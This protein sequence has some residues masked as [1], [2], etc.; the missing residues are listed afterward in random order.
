MS[1]IRNYLKHQKRRWVLA[2]ILLFLYLTVAGPIVIKLYPSSVWPE[3]VWGAVA[4]VIFALQI[5]VPRFIRCPRCLAG[6]NVQLSLNEKRGASATNYCPHCGV[7]IDS[8]F[9]A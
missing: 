9:A 7:Q 4:L 1:S 2:N 3:I 5:A 8:P 6:F